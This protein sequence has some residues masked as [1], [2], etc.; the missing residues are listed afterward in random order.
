MISDLIEAL[1]IVLSRQAS[2]LSFS[3]KN[4]DYIDILFSSKISSISILKINII[5]NYSKYILINNDD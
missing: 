1:L 2:I 5:I 3:A 4:L